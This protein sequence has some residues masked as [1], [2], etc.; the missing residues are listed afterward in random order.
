MAENFTN[1]IEYYLLTDLE[2]KES[3]A[4]IRHWSQL[5]VAIDGQELWIK[6]FTNDQLESVEIK[7]IPNK[8]IFYTKGA[9]LYLLNS[10][11]PE[12][13]VPSLLWTPIER[14]ISVQLPTLN[15][16]FFGI[17][18]KLQI[19]LVSQDLEKEPFAMITTIVA[20]NQYIQT[21]PAIRL[22][23]LDWVILNQ[24]DAFILRTPLLPLQ[25][26]VFWRNGNFLLPLGFNF[27]FPAL[28]ASMEKAMNP[29]ADHWIVWYSEV[30][31]I[32][33]S[34]IKVEALSISSFRQSVI[35]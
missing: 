33:I 34:K 6:S 19:K 11:L 15:H 29:E 4:T 17:K 7:S 31:Y 23:N 10:L 20:L 12:K 1:G 25:G 26:N 27:E 3:I 14:A 5:K 21:A 22:K 13:S 24:T 28:V 2:N 30:K 9:K 16:N 8:K 32:F 35:S 18:D